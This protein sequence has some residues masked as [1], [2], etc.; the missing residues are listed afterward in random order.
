[1]IRD[2]SLRDFGMMAIELWPVPYAILAIAMSIS[3]CYRDNDPHLP[4][5]SAAPTACGDYP[6]LG[7]KHATVHDAGSDAR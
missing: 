4:P 6:D 2:L 7:A 5:C 1:M 3:A